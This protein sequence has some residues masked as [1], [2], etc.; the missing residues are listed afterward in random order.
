MSLLTR[1]RPTASRR[2]GA[3]EPVLLLHP[4]MLSHHSWRPVVDRLSRGYDV[5]ALTLPGHY[6]GPPLPWQ[7][8]SLETL[9]AHVEKQMDEAG[10][11][12]AHLVGNSL[13]GWIALELARRGRARSVTAIAPGG[14]HAAFAVRDLAL[15]AAFAGV[16]TVRRGLRAVNLLPERIPLPGA[17]ALRALAPDPTVIA[18]SDVRHIVRA[19]LGATHPLQVMLA[20]ARARPAR[21]L[22]QIQVPVHLVFGEHDVVIP[23]ATHAPYFTSRLAGAEV[24]V[25]E[26]H[27]H[28]PQLTDPDLVADLVKQTI[29][30]SGRHLAVAR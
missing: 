12:T 18:A 2:A 22:E 1:H 16:A 9:V 28:C 10:W 5:L 27:G 15:G 23:T 8:A 30:R 25:L 3:G 26:E 21:G 24:S 17:F 11:S 19:S 4:L 20:Y 14:G 7:R 13:G 6:G 29:A